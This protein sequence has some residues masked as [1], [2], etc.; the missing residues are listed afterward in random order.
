[1]TNDATRAWHR[2]STA[3]PY[4]AD[5]TVEFVSFGP[6]L[7]SLDRRLLGD[8]RNQRVVELGCGMGHGAVALARQ[9]AKVIAVD[10]DATQVAH[11]RAL[12]DAH[13]VKIELHHADLADLAFCRSA[14]IDL[15]VS[16]YALAGVEDLDRVFRQVHRVLHP[17][18]AFVFSLPHPFTTLLRAAGDGSI[19]VVRAA[20]SRVPLGDGAL[21][22]YPHQFADLHT[23]LTRANFRVDVL[24]EPEPDAR[25]QAYNPAAGWVPTTVVVRARK[26]GI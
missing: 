1:M 21:V 11:A 18:A 8:L 19:R 17:E 24:L 7:P 20:N 10:P 15:L 5:R 13:R 6:D 16:T 9:G 22:T 12:A 2:Y 23:S 26:Q 14:S 3:H 25:T 4:A